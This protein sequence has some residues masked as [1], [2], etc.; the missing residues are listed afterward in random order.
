M[1]ILFSWKKSNIAICFQLIPQVLPE[2]VKYCS[3]CCI[4]GYE[5]S[6]RKYCY[7]SKVR[8]YLTLREP[9]VQSCALPLFFNNSG[10]RRSFE[11]SF[12]LFIGALNPHTFVVHRSKNSQWLPCTSRTNVGRSD[13][14]INFW[15]KRH[16]YIK[17]CKWPMVIDTVMDT[18]GSRSLK[19]GGHR[20]SAMREPIMGV[21]SWT[22]LYNK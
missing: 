22:Y 17:W 5:T 1:F 4:I 10:T 19:G 2:Y 6:D 3:T 12:D 7:A 11:I 8:S 16:K 13:F 15:I 14:S 18:G 20:A 21:W 9:G